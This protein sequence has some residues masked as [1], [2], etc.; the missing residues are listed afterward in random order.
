MLSFSIQS[1][2]IHTNQECYDLDFLDGEMNTKAISSLYLLGP[3]AISNHCYK[4]M[5][6]CLSSAIWFASEGALVKKT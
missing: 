5:M 6:L 4:G 2:C 3:L 1:I